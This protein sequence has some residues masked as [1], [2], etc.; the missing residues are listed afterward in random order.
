MDTASVVD[1]HSEEDAWRRLG[2]SP[3]LSRAVQFGIYER[4][5]LPFTPGEEMGDIP[6]N[7]EDMSLDWKISGRGVRKGF[8]KKSHETIP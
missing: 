6:Q 8:T 4:P 7:P 5:K 2:A 3:Y 1:S